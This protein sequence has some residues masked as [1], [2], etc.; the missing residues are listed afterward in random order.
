[1]VKWHERIEP[2]A[3]WKTSSALKETSQG[4]AGLE[5]L[6]LI[7]DSQNLDRRLSGAKTGL[8]VTS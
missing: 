8:V 1:M 5:A 7:A 2:N 6:R 4:R 3:A